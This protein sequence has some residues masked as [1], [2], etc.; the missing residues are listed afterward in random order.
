MT[1]RIQQI[2]QIVNERNI[3]CLFTSLGLKI[4][5]ALWLEV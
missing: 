3:K 2:Q 4:W 1:Q 5:K